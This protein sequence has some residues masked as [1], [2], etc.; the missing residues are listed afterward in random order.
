MEENVKLEVLENY[1]KDNLNNVTFTKDEDGV[2][3]GSD[4][5]RYIVYT[6]DEVATLYNEYEDLI[7]NTIETDIRR[8][9]LVNGY[10]IFTDYI[11]INKDAI[12]ESVDQADME[13][14][15]GV[16]YV[17]EESAYYKG[18]YYTICKE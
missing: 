11:E 14:V 2:Y 9:L 10:D 15:L 18:E 6:N 3:I 5:K 13:T 16:K 1:A 12:A 17:L 8:L 7:T 4:G